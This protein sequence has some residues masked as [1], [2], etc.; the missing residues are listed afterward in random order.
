VVDPTDP[1]YKTDS[2]FA[3]SRI[4]ADSEEGRAALQAAF[5]T[6]VG[7]V[8][9]AKW[10][11]AIQHFENF[12]YL[13][14][15]HVTRFHYG[16]SNGFGVSQA[17]GPFAD[18]LIAKQA[19]N[20]L[21]R[22]AETM[23]GMLTDASPE[24]RMAPNS[25]Q[26]EDEDAASISEIVTNLFFEKPLN[27]PKRLREAALLGAITGTAVGEIE[28]A[29]TAARVETPKLKE[30]TR[31]NALHDP[32]DPRTGPA[33]VTETVRDGTESTPVR[34]ITCRM[35]SH[36]QISVDPG[37]TT[38]D[39]LTWVA[40]TTFEDIDW[41]RENFDRDE[42]GY[43]GLSDE[44]GATPTVH[45]SQ[46]VLYW[47][48]R[49]QDVLETPQYAHL[50]SL[51]TNL[52]NT[53]GSLPNQTSFTV[54]DVKPSD[55]HPRG[56][57]LIFA[58]GK[59]VYAGQ[60][61]AW[62]EKYPW[63]WH[64]YAFW[65]WFKTPG[66][67]WGMPMLSELVPLQKKINAID[68]LVQANRQQIAL[69]QWLIPKHTHIKPGAMSGFVAEQYEYTAM[70]GMPGPERVPNMPL[71][72]ELIQERDQHIQAID[73]IA[74]IGITDNQIAKSAAR[75]G[76]ILD[77]LRSEK[78]R[79]K[80]SMIADFESFI[81]TM[82]QNVLIEIQ[83][84]LITEDERLTNR[85]R[86]A[87]R[88]FSMMSI[89]TFTGASLRDHHAIKIDISS[90]LRHSPEATEQRAVEFFQFAQ[91]QVSPSERQGL[92]KAMRLDGFVKN[93]QSASVER[94]R[95]MISRITQGMPEAFTPMPGVDD[96]TVMAPEFQQAILADTFY[97]HERETQDVLQNAFAHY[98]QAL[99]AL[100]QQQFEQQLLL[101]GNH[102]SQQPPPPPPGPPKESKAS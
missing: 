67:F 68:Y 30:V 100:Q 91:G 79:S 71:P 74:G 41:I 85:I 37:A 64:P 94:A 16:A 81:E 22:A 25:D 10:P 18:Y 93:E 72:Q 28:Y 90:S 61:R 32:K 29:D 66:K 82:G 55:E 45:A 5:T 46:H 58:G 88:D 36:F 23:V 89:Q 21:V 39:N 6:W 44:V 75:A 59:L 96:P 52:L 56:R 95:R 86:A 51:S 1:K 92:L 27:M 26:P 54:V 3:L 11:R 65:S 99:E 24:P 78:M 31:T 12:S 69:G 38:E 19:D 80:G 15:N 98:R 83:R 76:V 17:T 47:W 43:F 49:F 62:T 40:R 50:G 9:L 57:T 34:D 8:E 97:M 73:F 84:N 101:S 60:A 7:S 70:P 77:F 13:M 14:G 20:R 53:T 4:P 33:E 42:P 2:L 102:P 35:W 87:A 48:M 63:R